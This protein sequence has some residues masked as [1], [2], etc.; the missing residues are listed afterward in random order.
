[1]GA[2]DKKLTYKITPT[3]DAAAAKPHFDAYVKAAEEAGKRASDALKIGGGAQGI[4]DQTKAWERLGA[5]QKQA[6]EQLAQNAARSE[7]QWQRVAKSMQNT[8][9]GVEQLT[10]GITLLGLSGEADLEKI[11]KKLMAVEGLM[12]ALKGGGNLAKGASGL[13][14][15]R[16]MEA[17][18]LPGMAATIGG[19]STSGGG[20]AASTAIAAGPIVAATA[21]TLGLIGLMAE[22]AEAMNGTAK[23]TWSFTSK[24]A[25][26]GTKFTEVTGMTMGGA[27]SAALGRSAN[28]LAEQNRF[29]EFQGGLA[30]LQTQRFGGMLRTNERNVDLFAAEAATNRAAAD[31]RGLIARGGTS[32]QF[33]QNEQQHTMALE[34]ERRILLDMEATRRRMADGEIQNGRE[35]LANLQQQYQQQQAITREAQGRLQGARQGFGQMDALQQAQLIAA[36]RAARSGRAISREQSAL[37]RQGGFREG[38]RLAGEADERAAV[39]GG[40]DRNQLGREDEAFIRQSQAD[41][42]SFEFSIKDQRNIVVQ[43]EQNNQAQIDAVERKVREL[44][45][46]Q[47]AVFNRR[48]DRMFQEFVRAYNDRPNIAREAQRAAG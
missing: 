3:Y 46:E 15:M 18:S 43:L 41:T 33:A 35:V 47:D 8:V 16:N 27:S 5:G 31:R 28:R 39:R 26:L 11:V 9:K 30:E 10:R 1:M 34:S 37:L 19:A 7:F 12:A 42:R 2:E 21:A 40:V 20:A 23:E 22:L 14:A 25:W 6:Y 24:V 29:N 32:E 17:I 48:M 45:E 38:I 13:F 44:L 4:N 36:T